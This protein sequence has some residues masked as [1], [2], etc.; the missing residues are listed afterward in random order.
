[1]SQNIPSILSLFRV[2]IMKGC[3]VLS[4]TFPSSIER[5]IWFLS[6]LLLICCIIFMDLCMLSHP[7]IPEMNQ[8]GLGKRSSW[9][10]VE[11]C[12]PVFCWEYLHLFSLNILV[13]N[14]LFW[15]H[16]YWVW[17]ECNVN[18]IELVW[19]CSFPFHFLE[20]F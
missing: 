4:K 9:C 11:F 10:V 2:C 5:I 15:L 14:S 16:F 18:F 7:W 12:F 17:N 6:L 3:W 1:M 20:K 8:L 13:Y 19:K